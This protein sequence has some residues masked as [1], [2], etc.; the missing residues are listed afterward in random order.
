VGIEVAVGHLRPLRLQ[1]EVFAL[2]LVD[3][4][5][6]D[7]RLEALRLELGSLGLVEELLQRLPAR[8]QLDPA[9]L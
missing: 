7:D 2:V 1:L 5:V 8:L 4:R 3:Q 9:Q 6:V